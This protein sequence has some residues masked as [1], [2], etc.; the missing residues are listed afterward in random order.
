L[1]VFPLV[2]PFKSS[3][4]LLGV[5]SEQGYSCCNAC[6][7]HDS[8]EASKQRENS[9]KAVVSVRLNGWTLRDYLLITGGIAREV[10]EE[11]V[12]NAQL[13][14]NAQRALSWKSVHRAF[15]SPLAAAGFFFA[16]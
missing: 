15:R 12:V 8:T 9:I 14:R 16:Y 6:C 3:L 2:T 13:A 7:R 4:S 10:W 1:V 11:K 5:R